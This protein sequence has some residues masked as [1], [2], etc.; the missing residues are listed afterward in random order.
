MVHRGPPLVLHQAP[1]SRRPGGPARSRADVRWRPASLAW[2]DER[3]VRRAT[4]RSTPDTPA[5]RSAWTR[6][7]ATPARSSRVTGSAAGRSRAPPASV[8]ARW[9]CP[10]VRRRTDNAPTPSGQE[11]GSHRQRAGTTVPRPRTTRRS[12]APRPLN[13]RPAQ[14]PP[15]TGRD[16]AARPPSADPAMGSAPDTA[17]PPAAARALSPSTPPSTRCCD[18]QLNPP[19]PS[20]YRPTYLLAA[21]SPNARVPS[22]RRLHHSLPPLQKTCHNG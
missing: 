5:A 9:R 20:A 2:A 15:R 11:R 19:C 18:D 8:R 13:W 3:G 17:A 4:G 10:R 14:S 1:G 22:E 6:C 21:I 16:P 12:P 7:A